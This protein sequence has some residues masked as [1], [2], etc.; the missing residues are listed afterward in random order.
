MQ[1]K[2][3][4]PL[5]LKAFAH[6]L[7]MKKI[8]FIGRVAAIKGI[9]NLLKAFSSGECHENAAVSDWQLVITGPDQEGHTTEL[10]SLARELNIEDRVVFTGPKFGE[11]LQAAY[12][13]ADIFV[14]PSHSE[15][16]GS[17]VIEALA[18]EIPVITTKGT[19]WRELVNRGC[20]WWVDVGVEPLEKALFEAMSL[21][22]EERREMGM[23]GRR[24]VEEKYTWDAVATK[25][26]EGYETVVR[27]V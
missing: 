20:G 7:E 23:R 17:V 2:K 27:G 24:L 26:V 4:L 12:A 8:S 6:I 21:T 3:G 14:L 18:H 15:N 9:D 16:F 19:P 13:E 1:K 25:M 5:L 22:D 10:K 11:E